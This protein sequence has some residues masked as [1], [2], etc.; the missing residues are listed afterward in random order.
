MTKLEQLIEQ[1]CPDGVEYKVLG[2]IATISRGGS[3]QKKDFTEGGVP[4]IHYGQIYTRYG[5]FANETF[6]YISE[7]V[8]K[9]QKFAQPSD[10]V[11]AVTSENIEDVCKCVVWLGDTPAAVSGHSAIIHHDQNAKYLAYYFHSTMFFTQKRK[12]AQGTKVIEV[13]P[14]KLNKV[15]VPVPPLEVQA[16]IVRVLDTFT[17]LTTELTSELTSELTARK[18]QFKYYFEKILSVSENVPKVSLADVVD[19]TT[20][21]L[22]A[23]AMK[24]NGQYP[25]FTCDANPYRIDTYAFDTEA[26]LVSGNGSQIGH[27]NYYKGKFNAYQRTYVFSNFK[28]VNPMYLLAYLK[29]YLRD[30]IIIYAKKGSVPYITLPMLQKFLVPLPDFNTQELIAKRI[31]SIENYCNS[32]NTRLPAEIE[33]RQKQYEYYR[34]KL[35]QFAISN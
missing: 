6:T 7:S 9:K 27:I 23:N 8:A 29:A 20:G 24:E 11:M 15:K 2:D 4:C 28:G 1:L 35:L 18:K 10:I 32:L 26:I 22:N 12:I 33:A 14:D 3:F 25:F 31:N 13:S 17:E 5:L 30:Y 16:E 21:K 19:I 34:D